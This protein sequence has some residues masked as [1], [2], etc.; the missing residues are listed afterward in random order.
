MLN[1]A[2]QQQLPDLI[3]L[4]KTHKI[5]NAY[6]F[7]SAVTD[8]FNENSDVDFL[9]NFMDGLDPLEQGELKWSLRFALEDTIHRNIDLLS[10]NSLT[11]PYFIQSINQNKQLIYEH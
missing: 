3:K 9:I 7:G 8:K 2:I 4:F 6:L 10:E 5:K 1:P 11:N